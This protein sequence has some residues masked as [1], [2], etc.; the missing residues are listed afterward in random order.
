MSPLGDVMNAALPANFK[1]ASETK[2]VL[3]PDFEPGNSL[4][5]EREREVVDTLQIR[6][7]LDLKE[8][9]DLLGIKTIQ[10]LIK[11]LIDKRI[12]LSLEALND[13]FSP[14]T[15]IYIDLQPELLDE[16]E[17]NGKIAWLERRKGA[18]KQL[19]ALLTILHKGNYSNGAF[20]ALL[21]KEL[22]DLGISASSLNSLEKHGIIQQQRYEISRFG[23]HAEE[24]LAF[25]ALSNE[26]QTSLDE[27]NASF[28][29]NTT[30]LL[31]GVTG[32]GKTEIYVQLIQEQLDHGK[33]VLFLLPE[34]A[35]TTQLIQRLSAYFG[36]LVGVYHS[37]FNQN[38]RVEIW[39]HV[40]HND[41]S[42][43]RIILGARSSVFLPFQELGLIIVDEEHESTF[44]QY[45]PSPRYNAR[46]ASIVLAHLHN[47]KVLLGSATP[48]MESYFNAKTGKYGL[49]ELNSRFGGLRLPEIL[50]ADV[51][52]ERRQK[53]M[54]SHFTTF[55]IDEIREALHAQMPLLWIRFASCR[56]LLLLWFKT[57]ENVRL[58]N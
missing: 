11:K 17:L 53:N 20:T 48:S 7:T 27:I 5:N 4:L 49:V 12:V 14:K 10:P 50:C 34:I 30:T 6:E 29:K 41:P 35:L 22:I 51:K 1:L 24:Q 2:I 16:Q 21:K 15:A 8:L 47:A 57:T 23:N 58:W 19:E 25:K 31:R 40:L 3:H 32:S 26:Q 37:K 45:D 42:R 56:F 36:D 9:S 38:E 55:L 52:K 39:N 13:K 43:F 28:E 54:E 46:D 44:K 33:Q 18:D